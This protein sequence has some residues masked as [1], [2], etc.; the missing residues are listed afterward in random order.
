[1]LKRLIYQGLGIL[2]A[3]V[4]GSACGGKDNP[5]NYGGLGEA[6]YPNNTCNSGLVCKADTCVEQDGGIDSGVEDAGLDAKVD[7]YLDSSVDAEPDTGLDSSLDAEADAVADAEVDA[8]LDAAVDAEPDAYICNP[9]IITGIDPNSSQIVETLENTLDAT[10]YFQ[11]DDNCATNFDAAFWDDN[12]TPND[13]T[14]DLMIASGSLDA[15]ATEIS[16]K[17]SLTDGYLGDQ[18]NAGTHTLHLIINADGQP[19]SQT[20]TWVHNQTIAFKEDYMEWRSYYAIN[21]FPRMNFFVLNYGSAVTYSFTTDPDLF[22]NTDLPQIRG[23]PNMSPGRIEGSDYMGQYYGIVY[24]NAE[25]YDQDTGKT[26][27]RSFPIIKQGLRMTMDITS[28]G[29]DCT[30]YMTEGITNSIMEGIP[31]YVTK[32]YP[33]PSEQEGTLTI[34][35]Q[36]DISLVLTRLNNIRNDAQNGGQ[37]GTEYYIWKH[38]EQN[39]EG[40]FDAT[41]IDS[42]VLD[43]W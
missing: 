26:A 14:D 31:G 41:P 5:G 4:I 20:A 27:R 21:R 10:G 22:P 8:D 25:A 9:V 3:A 19:T 7:A 12:A 40:C 24:Y 34:T 38:L 37:W 15:T 33:Y 43:T 2:A 11:L 28:G 35:D 39:A 23:P 17:L 6:C 42:M 1:M 36:S 16:G 18:V 29:T 13:T 32:A 30:G